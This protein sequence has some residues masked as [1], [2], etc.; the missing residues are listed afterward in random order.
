MG[1]PRPLSLLTYC[2]LQELKREY[3]LQAKGDEG[4]VV[5]DGSLIVDVRDSA[6]EWIRITLNRGDAVVLPN[7]VYR[8][9]ICA[10]FGG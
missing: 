1:S 4:F 2:C 5:C 8:Y 6:D 10:P 9:S 3:R 7:T